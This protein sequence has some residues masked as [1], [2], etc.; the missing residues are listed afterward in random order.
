MRIVVST[1]LVPLIST[2]NAED[3]ATAVLAAEIKVSG[4]D[5]QPH[6][7]QEDVGLV[8]WIT[9]AHFVLVCAK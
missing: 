4:Y 2:F 5:Q 9:G 8:D 6:P 7:M 1:E 3:P